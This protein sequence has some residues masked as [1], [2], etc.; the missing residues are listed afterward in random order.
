MQIEKK[1]TSVK[2][3]IIYYSLN[4]TVMIIDRALT[5]YEVLCYHLVIKLFSGCTKAIHI[6][7]TILIKGLEHPWIF[8]TIKVLETIPW[9]TKGEIYIKVLGKCLW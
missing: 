4:N 2:E 9:V 7:Y 3:H 8:V 6:Y 1:L 5:L